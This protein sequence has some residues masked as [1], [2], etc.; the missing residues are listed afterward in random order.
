MLRIIDARTGEPVP[1]RR[2]LTRVETHVPGPGPTAPRLLLVAD[3]LV[4]ALDLGSTP[5]WAVL[6]T[7]PDGD[8]TALRATAKALGTRPFED[9][10][11]DGAARTFH[12]LDTGARGGA[13]DGVRLVVA[14]VEGAAPPDTDPAVLRLALLGSHRATPV[15]L[16]AETLTDAHDTLVRWRSAVAGWAREPSRP[17]PDEVR[18][19]LRAARED[20]LDT[21][22]V[23][24]VLRQ[25][26]DSDL[27]AGARFETYVHADRLLGLDLARDLGSPA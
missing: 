4:R 20:D 24:R 22:G 27:P 11:D 21:P 19:A 17:M 15:R 26:E 25:V 9:A 14:P 13:P 18:D 1:V 3:T 16:D 7:D 2:A 10:R 5:A 23:L 8:P 12:V 6:I